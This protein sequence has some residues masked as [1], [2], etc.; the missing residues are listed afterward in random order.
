MREAVAVLLGA[1]CVAS[2]SLAAPVSPIKH[3]VVIMMENRAFDHMLGYHP[4][5]DGLL[6][7]NWTQPLDPTD[8]KSKVLDVNPHA[9]DSTCLDPC[10]ALECTTAQIYGTETPKEGDPEVMDGFVANAA[11]TTL[12]EQLTPISEWTPETLP[13]LSTL[14]SN[15]AV[16]DKYFASV[17]GPTN[18]NRE[19]L[20]TGT[21][22]GMSDN[23]IPDAGF[24]QRTHFDQL[25][26]AGFSWN[27]YYSDNQW[28]APCFANLR[29]P[30]AQKNILPIEQFEANLAA[31]NLASYTLI[32]PR[33][34]AS[35]NGSCN[36]QHPECAISEGE[37]LYKWLYELLR[38][39]PVWN[40]TVMILNYDEHGGFFD[41]VAPPTKD[42]PNPDGLNSS[43]FSFDRLGIRV[44]LVAISPWI[45]AQTV[46]YPTSDNAPMPSSQYE[47]TSVIN[48]VNNLLGV[49]DTPL[50]KRVEWSAPFD[51]LVR[52]RTSPRTD[53]PMTLP[54]VPEAAPDADYIQGQRPLVEHHKIKIQIYCHL[55][56]RGPNCGK[57]IVRQEQLAPFIQELH[58]EWRA[59]MG[60]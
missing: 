46:S 15:F 18:P 34:S 55:T 51:F 40:D 19:Y 22:H 42:V 33:M 60:L 12:P 7:K 56:N 10:H 27:I 14:A 2:L 13:I 50:S 23:T 30:A 6:G 4:A 35:A 45:D 17:P 29:T 37:K 44:P 47:H 54:P 20:M 53:C 38:A 9:N 3:V 49:K 48:T 21:S 28:M 36:W 25:S 52:Q 1:A 43:D 11:Y 57:D 16:F 31:G 59:S 8:P 32:E 41:H 24:P 5:V 26:D 39:S 58:T